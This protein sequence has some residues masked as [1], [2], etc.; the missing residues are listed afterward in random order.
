MI[1]SESGHIRRLYFRSLFYTKNALQFAS[2]AAILIAVILTGPGCSPT[3]KESD[4]SIALAQS[5]FETLSE[6]TK[7]LIERLE[8]SKSTAKDFV[9]MANTWKDI[10]G[11][12]ILVDWNRK[13]KGATRDYEQCVTSK[14]QLAE[15]EE[16]ISEKICFRIR[17]EISV[18][19]ELFE[20][21]DVTKSRQSQCLGYCQLFYILGKTIDLSVIPINVVELQESGHLPTGEAHV[22]CVVS[23]SDGKTIM[24]NLVPGGLVSKPFIFEEKFKKTGNYWELTDKE[25]SLDIYRTIQLLN[26]KGLAA[27]IYNNRGSVN[28]SVG[29][30]NRALLNYNRAVELNPD[31]AEA[32]NN[33][34]IAYRNLDQLEKAVAD[35]SKAIELNPNFDEAYNNRGIANV[36]L[37]RIQQAVTDYD[38]AI[39]L[40]PKL[41]EAY[42]NRAN[43]YVRLRRF[44]QAISDYTKAIRRKSGFAQ[45]YGNRALTYALIGKPEGAKRDLRKAVKLSPA[46]KTYAQ[47][48]SERFQLDL[49]LD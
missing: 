37:G 15:I 38:K 28:V 46:L 41:A 33:R 39:E 16:S 45:A 32:Y 21:S 23:L 48:T 11:K 4:E 43:A 10:H 14:K 34:E 49:G 5:E 7:Q 3:L 26:E 18:N 36:K 31:F 40:N 25:N 9:D 13:L 30:Y 35:Y 17:R 24:L 29:Q 20:L 1:F 8:Y 22:S 27:Q 6:K 12:P 2:I 44:E 19:D 47:T 42:N